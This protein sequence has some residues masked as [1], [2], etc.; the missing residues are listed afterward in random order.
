MKHALILSLFVL[1]VASCTENLTTRNIM[2]VEHLEKLALQQ[3][4]SEC[5]AQEEAC[6]GYLE[7]AQ[8]IADRAVFKAQQRYSVRCSIPPCDWPDTFALAL[9][10]PYKTMQYF[11]CP[12]PPCDWPDTIF[13]RNEFL[14]GYSAAKLQSYEF[15]IVDQAENLVAISKPSD[16]KTGSVP[17][18]GALVKAR[19]EVVNPNYSGDAKLIVKRIDSSRGAPQEVIHQVNT[20]VFNA[21]E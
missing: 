21:K 12:V 4:I 7:L 13:A 11:W 17:K 20:R 14:I 3:K 10:K 9:V 16:K 6:E 18:E 2:L 8:Q 1:L 15:S 19:F 5:I